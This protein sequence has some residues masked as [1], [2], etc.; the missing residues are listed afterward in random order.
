MTWVYATDT[1]LP[2]YFENESVCSKGWQYSRGDDIAVGDPSHGN[3]L[4][5][6]IHEAEF[7]GVKQRLRRASHPRCVRRSLGSVRAARAR[8]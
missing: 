5:A 4:V 2:R 7:G 1:T 3:A 6:S 8:P